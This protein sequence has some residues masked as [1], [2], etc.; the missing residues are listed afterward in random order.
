MK[1]INFLIILIYIFSSS[2][3]FSQSQIEGEIILGADGTGSNGWV[4][5]RS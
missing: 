1:L 3:I 5:D 4:T 2:A